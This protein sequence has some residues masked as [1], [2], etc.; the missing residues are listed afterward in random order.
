M[1]FMSSLVKGFVRSAVNQ[2][3]RDGGKVISNKIYKGTHSTPI[4]TPGYYREAYGDSSPI[5]KPSNVIWNVVM[6]AVWTLIL[7][8]SVMNAAGGVLAFFIP[9]LFIGRLWRPLFRNYVHPKVSKGLYKTDRRFTTGSRRI[10]SYSTTDK[11]IQVPL[12]SPEIKTYRVEGILKLIILLTSYGFMYSTSQTD[13]FK[14]TNMTTKEKISFVQKGD[15]LYKNEKF[16]Y[17]Y[18][19]VDDHS[20]KYQEIGYDTL[21]SYVLF[22]GV[23]SLQTNKDNRTEMQRVKGS[24]EFKEFKAEFDIMFKVDP[25]VRPIPNYNAEL[26]KKKRIG[27]AWFLN[28]FDLNVG[29]EKLELKAEWDVNHLK[30][31]KPGRVKVESFNDIEGTRTKLST[32]GIGDFV[33]WRDDEMGGFTSITSYYT[34]GSNKLN[35]LAYYLE[36]DNSAY[37]TTLKLVLNI[38]NKAEKGKAL[39]KLTE[40][41]EK[42]FNVLNL[43]L[44]A[45]LLNSIRKEKP[46]IIDG[47]NFTSELKLEKSKIDTWIIKVT[48]KK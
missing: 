11:S 1:S 14:L 18:A 46:L 8:N 48:S 30:S 10:G 7:P 20:K 22:L 35:N 36:S 19:L 13:K 33:K 40:V 6:F 47:E 4:G 34:F 17:Y 25:I 45:E 24:P 9:L 28:P 15:T 2:V 21:G 3:G 32:V 31:L 12:E 37:V 44:P 27:K 42:T 29:Q 38:N 16:I 23:D 41:T 39:A 5:P 26:Y 43:K